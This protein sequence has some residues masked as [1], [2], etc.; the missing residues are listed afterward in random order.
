MFQKVLLPL[1]PSMHAGNG[2]IRG[3]DSVLFH[4][5][6]IK[7]AESIRVLGWSQWTLR[8]AEGATGNVSLLAIFY[9][10]FGKNDPSLIIPINTL[11]H[12][13]SGLFI[14]L[15]ARHLWPDKVGTYAGI[16]TASL[17]IA[18]PSSL[19]WY[20]QI[21]KDGFAILGMLMIFY[22]WLQV[23]GNVTRLRLCAWI[24]I[25]NLV[26]IALVIFVRPY[27]LML[28]ASSAIVIYALLLA[29]FIVKREIRKVIYFTVFLG[30][31]VSSLGILNSYMPKMLVI[32]QKEMLVNVMEKQGISWHWENSK[33]IP[34]TVDRVIENASFLRA[35]TIYYGTIV[36]A[37]SLLDEDVRPVNVW[38]SLAYLPRT[39]LIAVFAPFPNKWFVNKSVIHLVSAGETALWYVLVPGVFFAFWYRRSL[40]L[41]LLAVNSIVFL[42]I[43]GFTNPNLGTLYR[44]RYL[45]LFIL[46]L[47]GT[48][49]WIELIRRKVRKETRKIEKNDHNVPIADITTENVPDQLSGRSI[50]ITAGFTVIIFTFLS[51]VLLVAR[52]IVLARW[53]GL[54]NQLDAFFIAMIVPMFLVTIMSIPIGT[55]TIPPLINMFKEGQRKKTQQLITGTSTMIFCGMSVITLLLY[56]SGRYY[57]PIIGWGFPSEKMILVQRIF[58]IV[59]PIL[60]FSGFVILGNSILNARQKFALPALAQAIVPA[61]AIFALLIAAEKIGIYAMAAGM[62]IGQ[63]ANLFIVAYYV[64]REGYTISPNIRPSFI[65]EL[66]GK[67]YGQLRALSLQYAPLVLA[68]LFLTLTLPVSNMIAA[69]LSSGNVSAYNVGSKFI[70]FFTGLVGTGISTVLLPHFSQYFAGN[71]IID[72]KRELSFFLVLAA[73]IPIP[74]TVIIFAL[75]PS[76]VNLVF[77]GGVFSINDIDTVIK[78][79]EYGII[80]ISFFCANMILVKFANAKRKNIL[81]TISSLFGL[82]MNIVLSLVFIRSMGVAG[83]ALASSVSML[84]ATVLLIGVGYRY[85]DI[86]QPDVMLIIVTWML[87]MTMFLY[88]YYNN[89]MGI[90]LTAIPLLIAMICYFMTFVDLKTGGSGFGAIMGYAKNIIVKG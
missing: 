9:V 61:I 78:I 20:A 65:K 42:T 45:Y 53:F 83:I 24:I 23:T 67:P 48:M 47:I 28:L 17:F 3:G 19:N 82:V 64:K 46:M 55:V 74:L 81:V 1:V 54:S 16:I 44:F 14:F 76:I 84:L 29:Y 6:A 69:S 35:I 10:I 86:S 51:N 32:Q 57:L 59:L 26:G 33:L 70:L 49:G 31:F 68:A 71:R 18:F 7:L 39:A 8:P 30:I 5:V 75:T 11:A 21:H 36:K 12:A 87:Y 22:S 25:G 37:K 41:F 38:S 80:Q 90:A 52:D 72:V 56:I 79:M 89:I 34:D 40:P 13:T 4:D 63:I 58:I 77:K 43:L 88:Y 60:F 85:G 50:V 27:N 15:I 62:L 73:L 66:V 2:L